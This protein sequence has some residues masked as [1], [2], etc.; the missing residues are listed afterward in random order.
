MISCLVSGQL[1]GVGLEVVAGEESLFF[2][3]HAHEGIINTAIVH[4]SPTAS[5]MTE[6]Q[7]KKL[8]KYYAD[9][10]C[11]PNVVAADIVRAI[12]TDA[13]FLFTGPGARLGHNAMRISRRLAR[14]LTIDAARKSG[15][16]G[17]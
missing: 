16:L 14:R 3:N 9:E 15:Y 12:V 5:G 10:G 17:D 6:T 13:S 7:I 11:E 2:G 8:Q 1:S 4:V